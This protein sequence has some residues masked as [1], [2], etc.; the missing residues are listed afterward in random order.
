MPMRRIAARM[1]LSLIGH[2]LLRARENKAPAPGEGMQFAQYF[3][4]LPGEGDNVQGF[5]LGHSAAPFRPVQVDVSP[6]GLA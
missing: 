5:G 4:G 1:A 3:H 6:F 2:P